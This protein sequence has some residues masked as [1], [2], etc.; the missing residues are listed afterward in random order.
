MDKKGVI[1]IKKKR[2]IKQTVTL[3]KAVDEFIHFSEQKNLS[4]STITN[5]K[6]TCN[7]LISA[8]GDIEI[9]ELSQKKI[10]EFADWLKIN[11]DYNAT[12]INTTYNFI[13]VF[14]NFLYEKNY[15]F[16][17]LKLKYI[18]VEKK[19]KY[20][21][22]DAEIKIL[23]KKPDENCVFSEYRNYIIAHIV[24]NLGL[25]LRTMTHIQIKH[26]DMKNKTIELHATK[27]RTQTI[28]KI[29]KPL[30][31]ILS[32]YF[33]DYEFSEND[34]LI[35]DLRGRKMI[36]S[37]VSKS[38]K[39]YCHNRKIFK[40]G[41]VHLLR[42]TFATHFIKNGGSIYALSKILGHS[43]IAITE[44]YIRTLNVE[45]FVEDLEKF[46]LISHL[47]G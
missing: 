7:S 17:N 16:T 18:K 43:S 22:S 34:Y 8:I 38:F 36:E 42:H 26:I 9:V 14:L 47:K 32:E 13:N 31:K 24:L 23:L 28:I 27:N 30:Y 12:S 25:R 29:P 5:Y 19:I 41:S 6:F 3:S 1:I 45:H 39:C 15:I 20:I 46:N 10:D 35:C 40:E 44:N 37:S 2:R 11:R 33:E 4:V 21:Y